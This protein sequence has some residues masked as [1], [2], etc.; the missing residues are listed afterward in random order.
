MSNKL[1]ILIGL[2]G[3]VLSID[4]LFSTETDM[5]FISL[6]VL[7]CFIFYIKKALEKLKNLN[8]SSSNSH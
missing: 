1:R 7:P 2:I 8:N 4:G 5:V 6:F 3:V